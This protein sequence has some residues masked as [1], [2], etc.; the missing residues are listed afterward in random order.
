MKLYALTSI[1]ADGKDQQKCGECQYFKSGTC[2][3]FLTWKG[4]PRKL[5]L[6]DM[7]NALRCPA[8]LAASAVHPLIEAIENNQKAVNGHYATEVEKM[9][10]SKEQEAILHA[11]AALDLKGKLT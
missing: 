11:S 3:A 4:R 8:C 10:L 6:N 9:W 5:C 2:R 7:G 1:E